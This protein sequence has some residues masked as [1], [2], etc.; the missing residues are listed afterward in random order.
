MTSNSL[1]QL[2]NKAFF[3][4]RLSYYIQGAQL[5]LSNLLGDVKDPS[6][7]KFEELVKQL[8]SS[9]DQLS[10]VNIGQEKLGA[11]NFSQTFKTNPDSLQKSNKESLDQEL[12]L[13]KRRNKSLRKVNLRLKNQIRRL[14]MRI[15]HIKFGFAEYCKLAQVKLV[16]KSSEAASVQKKPQNANQVIN[17]TKKDEEIEGLAQIPALPQ[18]D[19][20]N[21]QKTQPTKISKRLHHKAVQ[22]ANELNQITLNSAKSKSETIKPKKL[23]EQKLINRLA[24]SAFPRSNL[25][26]NPFIG[27]TCTLLALKDQNNMIVAT[28]QKG[29]V[30]FSNSVILYSSRFTSI[31]KDL[32][33]V[34][35]LSCYLMSV[36]N[37]LY[38][39]DIDKQPP[40]PFIENLRCGMMLG[41]CLRYSH[42]KKLIISKDGRHISV[43]DLYSKEVEIEIKNKNHGIELSQ[44]QLAGE[45]EDRVVAV[46]NEN[47]V[48]V[49]QID[50]PNKKGLV[51]IMGQI[52]I[53]EVPGKKSEKIKSISVCPDGEYVFIEIGQSSKPFYSTRILI[54]GLRR[55]KLVQARILEYSKQKHAIKPAIDCYGY[56]GSHILWVG[57]SKGRNGKAYVYDFDV[58]TQELRELSEITISHGELTPIKIHRSGD[59]HYYVGHKGLIKKLVLDFYKSRK[60]W[61]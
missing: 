51:S 35:D 56:L 24:L 52:P 48:I 17:P 26:K 2:N 44:F 49:H 57:L 45:E 18:P 12:T 25:S 20:Q 30:L 58:Q 47:L 60:W 50:Y 55:D 28:Q 10:L 13:S 1:L 8:K 27:G 53:A 41:A 15:R 61:R 59:D 54:M 32:I 22:A 40:Y 46:G 4:Q 19:D 21:H 16:Q 36:G 42:N 23:K 7:Q 34:Q 43:V 5:C 3:Q 6:D 11:N 29:I 37:K 39:K 31:I 14:K 9:I 33:Y 38:R